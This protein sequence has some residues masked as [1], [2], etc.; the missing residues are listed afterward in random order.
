MTLAQLLADVTRAADALQ[1][2][3][4]VHG[5][6]E[7]KFHRVSAPPEAVAEQLANVLPGWPTPEVIALTADAAHSGKATA[8][9]AIQH[10]GI[11]ITAFIAE[12]QTVEFMAPR[13]AAKAA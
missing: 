13:K 8:W 5:A 11:R 12:K 3:Q 9:V 10:Q 4:P 1:T 2:V 6:I 7:L